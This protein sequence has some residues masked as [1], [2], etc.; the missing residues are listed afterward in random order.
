M[1]EPYPKFELTKAHADILEDVV[2][3]TKAGMK[4]ATKDESE[5]VELDEMRQAGLVSYLTIH[6]NASAAKEAWT[7]TFEGRVALQKF[8]R[9][10][11]KPQAQAKPPIVEERRKYQRRKKEAMAK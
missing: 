1:T 4:R 9:R 6:E 2:N 5:I 7:A 8:K 3:A 10:Q 11:A